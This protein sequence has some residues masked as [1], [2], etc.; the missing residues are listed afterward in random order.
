MVTFSL[1]GAEF[2]G[3]L[4]GTL[5]VLFAEQRFERVHIAIECGL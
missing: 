4:L 1:V 2:I 5:Q 3:T